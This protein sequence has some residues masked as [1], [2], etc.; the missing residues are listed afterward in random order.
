VAAK[1]ATMTDGPMSVAGVL[2]SL[3][4]RISR[5][6]YWLKGVVPVL[7]IGLVAGRLDSLLHTSFLS[8]IASVAVLYPMFAITLKRLHDRERS[9]WFLLVGLVPFIGQAWVMIELGLLSGTRGPN[10]Y[11]LDQTML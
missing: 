10:R 11:G 3:E 6:Q 2:F 8:W 7:L 5:S 9:I 4:G 1:E